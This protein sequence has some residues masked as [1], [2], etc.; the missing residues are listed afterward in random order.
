M[1]GCKPT[2]LR[3]VH[4]KRIEQTGRPQKFPI[5]SAP[6]RR[7]AT[8]A[9]DKHSGRLALSVRPL[10]RLPTT[11]TRRRNSSR[12][13]SSRPPASPG[14]DGPFHGMPC[15]RA[16]PA[17]DGRPPPWRPSTNFL[18]TPA[19]FPSKAATD[20][21]DLN[22]TSD[23]TAGPSTVERFFVFF[24]CISWQHDTH[25][26]VKNAPDVNQRIP[27]Q[28]AVHLCRCVLRIHHLALQPRSNRRQTGKTCRGGGTDQSTAIFRENRLERNGE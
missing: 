16:T 7:V 3:F 23:T 10:Q 15:A 8:K 2:R 6:R 4:D 25:T 21:L 5:P 22:P 26:I 13:H 20:R 24:P 17:R 14:I 27:A 9:L 18:E 19:H 28:S 1:P 12:R 11:A